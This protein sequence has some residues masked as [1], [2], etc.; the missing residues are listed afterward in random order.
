MMRPFSANF[1]PTFFCQ[2]PNNV[3]ASG[4][5]LYLCISTYKKIT[6]HQGNTQYIAHKTAISREH[7][8]LFKPCR[9]LQ[10]KGDV[11]I[12]DCLTGRAFNQII[13][14]G[15]DDGP[16]WNAVFDDADDDEI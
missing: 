8:H 11:E 7:R 3:T 1:D 16:S 2:L 14:R 13:D 10:P 4:H 12:L 15:N 5:G 6:T 9:F